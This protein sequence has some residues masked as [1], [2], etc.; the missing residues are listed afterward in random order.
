MRLKVLIALS[1]FSAC[2]TPLSA[3]HSPRVV[4]S[5]VSAIEINGTANI[6]ASCFLTGEQCG[7]QEVLISEPQASPMAVPPASAISLLSMDCSQLGTNAVW[8]WIQDWL[9]QW[10][11]RR[12]AVLLADPLQICNGGNPSGFSPGLQAFTALAYGLGENESATVRA[13]DFVSA[14]STPS[15]TVPTFAFSNDP[16][17]TVRI[18]GCDDVGFNQ[19]ELHLLPADAEEQATYVEVIAALSDSQAYCGSTAAA[20]TSFPAAFTLNIPF[21]YTGELVL[22]AKDFLPCCAPDSLQYAFSPNPSDNM[23]VLDCDSLAAAG[24]S[25]AISIYGISPDG[26]F[27]TSEVFY[28]LSDPMDYCG[29]AIGYSPPNDA[30]CDAIELEVG[31]FCA[32]RSSNIGASAEMGEVAPT[33]GA[34]GTSFTWCD[35]TG[36][37][38][39]VWFQFE[40]P[41]SGS[42]RIQS[43]FFNTQLALWEASN[44]SSLTDGSAVLVAAVDDT[45]ATR[46]AL[47]DSLTCLI[48]GQTYFLQLDEH[49]EAT[50]TFEL[51]IEDL[52]IPCQLAVS[53]TGECSP[54]ADNP[55][56]QGYN[57]WQHAT[58]GE[59]YVIASFADAGQALGAI[60]A[61]F[62]VHDGDIRADSAGQFYLDRNWQVVSEEAAS[63][64]LRMRLYFTADEWAALQMAAPSVDSPEDVFLTRVPAGECGPFTGGGILVEQLASGLINETDYYIDFEVDGFSAFYLNGPSALTSTSR[65][66]ADRGQIEVFPNPSAGQPQLKIQLPQ[67]ATIEWQLLSITGQIVQQQQL[68]AAAG[69]TVVP[70]VGQPLPKGLYLLQVNSPYGKWSRRVIIQ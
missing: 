50:G 31:R 11:Y 54:A 41:A 60:E 52:G 27:T 43:D 19:L 3:Q 37:D 42:V 12:S 70:V 57:A 18:L 62:Q 69:K 4:S 5:V 13:R 8:I 44:C 67:A 65:P 1:F 49:G 9:G 45:T 17:D 64:A 28:V 63:Q 33:M 58:N 34:C 56:S 48:P 14:Y 22:M 29:Q 35:G 26:S 59:G 40:A 47:L 15:N 2:L 30:A 51:R 46:G 32:Y 36:P 66:T 6:P 23:R 39:S 53:N 61:H 16:A 38:H 55:V 20:G 68:N 21:S 25:T 24:A 10:S 7:V